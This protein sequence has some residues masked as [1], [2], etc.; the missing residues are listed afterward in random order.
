MGEL[1]LSGLFYF[2]CSICACILCAFLFFKFTKR[3]FG[4]YDIP[5]SL[6]FKKALVK[7]RS[8][9]QVLKHE[10]YLIQE[11]A[12]AIQ[13]PEND[14]PD[15]KLKG[16]TL[17]AYKQMAILLHNDKKIWSP[18]EVD[19]AWN[20]FERTLYLDKVKPE[21]KPTKVIR[22]T[23]S[24]FKSLLNQLSYS[25]RMIDL[26]PTNNDR[27]LEEIHCRNAVLYLLRQFLEGL[28]WCKQDN[29]IPISFKSTCRL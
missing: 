14:Y 18:S 6:Q 16:F 9:L 21:H 19:L 2:L 12:N 20:M 8:E 26:I 27:I 1:L 24:Y 23:E 15:K 13:Y 25:N 10:K 5:S 7:E 11:L 29:I 3:F 17:E 22:S 4:R 28:P